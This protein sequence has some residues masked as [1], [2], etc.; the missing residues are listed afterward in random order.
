MEADV[1]TVTDFDGPVPILM[2]HA[3][4]PAPEGHAN[5]DLFVPQAAFEEQMKW[6]A[7]EGYN[8]VTLGQV[9][10]AWEDGEPI[11]RRPI[12][13][14]FDDGLRS[15]YVAGRPVLE[16]FGW[17]GVLNLKLEAVDQGELDEGMVDE[18]IAAG[19][20]IDAHSLTHP[21]LTTLDAAALEEQVAG[22]REQIE[23]RFG[24]PADFFCYP[25]GQFDAEVIAAVKEAGYLGA[26]TTEP[27]LAVADEAYELKRIRVGPG[28]GGAELAAKLA[29]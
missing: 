18:L 8:A 5:P 3:I 14:S 10:A 26:T 24:Q 9:F 17:P 25:A 7:D 20:E 15:Q 4:Q 1:P 19:W 28:D 29:A 11:A 6:V 16:R 13:V 23:S 22:S 12:V 27:G 2:Y 21:D